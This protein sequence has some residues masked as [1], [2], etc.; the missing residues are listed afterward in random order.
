MSDKYFSKALYKLCYMLLKTVFFVCFLCIILGSGK[1]TLPQG[2]R[3]LTDDEKRWLA[4][5]HGF[6]KEYECEFDSEN[7]V[8]VQTNRKIKEK[9]QDTVKRQL[10]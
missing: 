2:Y 8:L 6:D 9:Q 4:I 10:V 3:E 1:L 5:G 7:N